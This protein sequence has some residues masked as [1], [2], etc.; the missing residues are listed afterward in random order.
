MKLEEFNFFKLMKG[1]LYV[2]P[3]QLNDNIEV[4]YGILG[5]PKDKVGDNVAGFLHYPSGL[6]IGYFNDKINEI[7]I[8]FIRGIVS[9]AVEVDLLGKKVINNNT[10]AHEF[11]EILNYLFIPWKSINEKNLNVF[12]III[13]D[14]IYAFF[15]LET[16]CITLISYPRS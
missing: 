16:G 7:G 14:F 12:S 10:K 13:N 9:L 1:N 6:R 2:L 4:V 11:I 5:Q 15:D 8:Y 3:F